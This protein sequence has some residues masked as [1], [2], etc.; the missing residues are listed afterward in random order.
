MKI[1]LLGPPGAGKGTQAQL[2]AKHYALPHISTGDL[3]RQ[4]SCSDDPL[5]QEVKAVMRSGKLVSDEVIVEIVWQRLQKADCASGF[6]FDGFPRTHN[7]AQEIIS[8]GITVSTIV[9][10]V[11]DDEEIIQRLSGR[12]VHI[13]SGR[14]YH[15]DTA[16]PQRVGYDNDTGEELAIRD[17]DQPDALTARLQTYYKETAVLVNFYRNLSNQNGPQYHQVDGGQDIMQVHE[18][19]L[20]CVTE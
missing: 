8:R 4:I 12:R 20:R 3:L 18:A 14:I 10:I 9:E 7:Q 6:I 15:I 5:G 1:I 2:L 11:I 16:P 19:I 13:P 17:D